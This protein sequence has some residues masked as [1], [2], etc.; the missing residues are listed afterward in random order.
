MTVALAAALCLSQAMPLRAPA[1][2]PETAQAAALSRTQAVELALAHNPQL[3]AARQQIAEA[4]AGA[5]QATA[6]ADPSLTATFDQLPSPYGVTSGTR[7][8][9]LGL[10]VPLP[11]KQ[12]LRGR[13]ARGDVRVA[14]LGYTTLRQQL[15]AQAVQGYDALLV[16]LRHA[17]DLEEAHQVALEF[18]RRTEAR[19]QGGTAARLDVVKATVDASQVQTD[20]IGAQRDIANARAQLNRLMGRALGAGLEPSDTL[21]APPPIADLE[22]LRALAAQ[23]RP[24]L[25]AL[26]AQRAASRAATQLARQYWLP[27]LSLGFSS[28]RDPGNP[29][30]Y[31]TSVGFALPLLFWQHRGGEVAQ[32]VH[33]ERELAAQATDAAAQ[34][35]QEIRSAYAD[36]STALRQ[37]AFIRDQLLP[38]TQQA[39]SIASSSYALGGSSALEVLDA[40]RALLDAQQQY[41]EALGAANDAV[42]QLELAAGGGLPPATNP[43]PTTVTPSAGVNP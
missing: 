15:A 39:Y 28:T 23:N 12:V 14:E 19:Y 31:T 34:V 25:Q 30:Y 41:A 4:R 17:R 22:G 32:A 6:I 18:V 8:L 7:A 29:S 43:S 38:V 11:Q 3:E 42:A 16:A 33:R 9:N 2:P 5:V 40:R 20:L 27:D 37:V 26:A 21:A 10:T 36:A 1:A 13:V 35:E 24:E